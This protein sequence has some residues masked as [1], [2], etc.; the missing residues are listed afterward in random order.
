[1]LSFTL[2]HIGIFSPANHFT[3][4]KQVSF[5][6]IYHGQNLFT[7]FTRT[8]TFSPRPPQ[9]HLWC[10]FPS[11]LQRLRSRVG[12]MD[13]LVILSS[14]DSSVHVIPV[15]I[16]WSGLREKKSLYAWEW[17]IT[18]QRWKVRKEVTKII[19]VYKW[20]V[21]ENTKWW[22]FDHLIQILTAILYCSMLCGLHTLHP[23]VNISYFFLVKSLSSWKNPDCSKV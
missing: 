3:L 5:L 9:Q 23:S 22:F 8:L 21:N 16:M 2:T 13:K 14:T 18:S 1:M 19:C 7:S 11:P 6:R 10:T 17:M 20:E 15:C 4:Y 12:A